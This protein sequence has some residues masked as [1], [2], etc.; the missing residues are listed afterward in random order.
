MY[1]FYST[2]GLPLDIIL[3]VLL[4]KGY[5]V[6]WLSLYRDGVKAGIKPKKWLRIIETL[7]L[8]IGFGRN[9]VVHII[10]T[11]KTENPL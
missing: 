11:I 7:L 10:E 2:H 5:L 3:D 9:K 4:S 6:C 1:K 8:D